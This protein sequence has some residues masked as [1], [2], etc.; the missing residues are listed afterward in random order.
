M[1]RLGSL[2]RWIKIGPGEYLTLPGK[3]VRK[4]S[5]TFNSPGLVSIDIVRNKERVFLAAPYRNEIV[6][7]YADGNVVITTDDEDVTVLSAETEA[8]SFRIEGPEVF[9]QIAQRASRNPELERMMHLQQVNTERRLA[10][11]ARNAEQRIEAAFAAGAERGLRR[12]AESTRNIG[13]GQPEPAPN[14]E[15]PKSAT[16]PTGAPPSAENPGN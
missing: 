12:S 1:I 7:F 9:T 6:E 2:E 8:T 13:E 5:L 11:L 10:T 14:V 15:F 4:L 16:I 3:K